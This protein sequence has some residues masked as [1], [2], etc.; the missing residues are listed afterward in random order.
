MTFLDEQ[1]VGPCGHSAR[2]KEILIKVFASCLSH[3]VPRQLA[4]SV[5]GYMNDKNTGHMILEYPHEIADF[6]L[7]NSIDATAVICGQD[8]IQDK[9]LHLPQE[10]WQTFNRLRMIRRPE[11]DR[12]MW[13]LILTKDYESCVYLDL[14]VQSGRHINIE[15]YSKV[16]K[17]G[18]GERPTD[19]ERASIIKL[20]LNGSLT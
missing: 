3:Q 7:I 8:S 20:Y 19:E 9:C 12:K 6:Q 5:R 4:F 14:Q 2:D 10:N 1:G 15:D 11:R 13:D 17:S 18:W 16:L